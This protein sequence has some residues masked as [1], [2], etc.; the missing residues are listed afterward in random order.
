M[1][2]EF[3]LGQME[4]GMKVTGEIIKLTVRGSSGMWMG[5]Y[6]RENGKMIKLMVLVYTPT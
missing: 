2:M 3:R 4:P 1:G 5:I 6:L